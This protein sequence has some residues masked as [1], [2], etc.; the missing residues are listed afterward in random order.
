MPSGA[1]APNSIVSTYPSGACLTLTG[2]D[3]RLA[4]FLGLLPRLA[5][6]PRVCRAAACVL[7]NDIFVSS[8][9]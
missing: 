1:G 6:G 9:D 3:V 8:T 2:R 5:C 7:W 4:S